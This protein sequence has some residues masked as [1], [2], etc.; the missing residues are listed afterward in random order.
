MV[1]GLQVLRSGE[2]GEATEQL[3]VPP[4]VALLFLTRGPLPHEPTWRLFLQAAKAV[5]PGALAAMPR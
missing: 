1:C 3:S 2:E 5:S 4:T